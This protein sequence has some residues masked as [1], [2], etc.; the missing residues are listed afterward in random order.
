MMKWQGYE[1]TPVFL[2]LLTLK[3]ISC[4][5]RDSSFMQG[6]WVFAREY[7]ELG[8][9]MPFILDKTKFP[10]SMQKRN[11][12][13]NKL[14]VAL[15][16][17]APLS[18][19]AFYYPADLQEAKNGPAHRL[20]NDLV[21]DSKFVIAAVQIVIASLLGYG[22]MKMRKLIRQKGNNQDFNVQ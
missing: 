21:A 14:I 17:A 4:F 15:N 8:Q 6:H 16:V 20:S 12:R 18:E 3:C 11:A 5:V 10:V 22:I 19:A 1:I 2:V 9:K 13:I 7:F